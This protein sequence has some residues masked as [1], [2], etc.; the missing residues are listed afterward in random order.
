M[1]SNEMLNDTEYRDISEATGS[2]CQRVGAMKLSECSTT[3]LKM[4]KNS[5]WLLPERPESW[6]N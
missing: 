6:Y 3:D 4:F 5:Q 1:F 2:V